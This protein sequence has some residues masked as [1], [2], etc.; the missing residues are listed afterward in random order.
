MRPAKTT[1]DYFTHVTVTGKTIFTLE[2]MYGNDGYAVWFK[3][4]ELLGRTPGH[5]YK[6]DSIADWT[7]LVACYGVDEERAISILQTLADLGAIDPE[8]HKEKVIWSD[9][10]MS[11]LQG[12]YE[13]RSSEIPCKPSFRPENSEDKELPEITG[14]KTPQTKLNKTKGNKR[15]E[16]STPPYEKIIS[17]LNEKAKTNFKH[18]SKVT[19]SHINARF[20]EGYVLEDFVAVIDKKCVDWLNDRKMAEFLRPST[21]F[22]TKFEGYLQSSKNGNGGAKAAG[23]GEPCCKNCDHEL[24]G[25]CPERH[26]QKMLQG[27]KDHCSGWQADTR[28]DK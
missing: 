26:K 19:R 18:T 14:E 28:M 7:Y 10:L 3:T 15:R 24:R 21:L 23:N 27:G 12:V 22:G 20:D 11:R 17:H 4:L 2:R 25:N 8:L 5:Y 13:K 6:Y 9:N 1:V 16:K